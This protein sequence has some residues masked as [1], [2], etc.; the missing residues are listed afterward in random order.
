MSLL[1]LMRTGVSGMAGQSNRLS[2][3]ADNVANSG[4]VGYKAAHTQFSSLLLSGEVGSYTSGGVVTQNRYEIS[5]Q[6][7]LVQTSSEFDLAVLGDGFF[8]VNDAQ[9]RT[10]LTRAGSFVPNGEGHLRNAAGQTLLG[11]PLAA[12]GSA[13]DAPTTLSGLFPI[14]IA[15]QG[16]EAI[17]STSGL[18]NVTLPSGATAVAAGDLPSTNSATAVSTGRTSLEVFGNRGERYTM[19]VYF[20][21]TSGADEWEVA[22]YD[23]SGRSASGGFPYTVGPVAQQTLT[24][25]LLGSLSSTS[26]SDITIPVPNGQSMT[27]D[28]SQAKMLATDF[29]ILGVEV[30][31]SPPSALSS[32]EITEKGDVKATYE[33]GAQRSLYRIALADVASP[34]R[35]TSLSG[36]SYVAND[37]SG[38]IHIGNPASGGLGAVVS[39]AL[40]SSTVDLATELTEMIEAQRNY[41]ANSK[42][43]QTGAELLDVLVNLKR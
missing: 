33:N 5:R 39:G 4:T 8:V 17:P 16:L 14:E 10:V 36:N 37:Q 15:Q 42:V 43:V 24:Y 41:T 25:D 30:N 28:L 18:L 26:A 22:I 11:Y 2:A 27:L 9:G 1:G 19:D 23:A 13:T 20:A 6:G 12:D 31:G 32:I 38:D 40:E 7:S 35:L 21:R 34:D 29:S 3:I